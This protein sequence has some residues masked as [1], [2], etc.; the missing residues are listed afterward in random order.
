M[1]GFASNGAW[2]FTAALAALFL[3][4]GLGAA[5]HFVGSG[6]KH[7]GAS[8]HS[9]AVKGLSEREVPASIAVWTVTYSATGNELAEIDGKLTQ[10]TASVSKYLKESGFG[11]TDIAVQP[12]AVVD[13]SLAP[14]GKDDLPPVARFSA[15]QSVLLRTNKVEAVKPAMAGAA[16]LIAAG[17]QLA[18][19]NDPT[20]DFQR[21]NDIKPGM[22]AEATRNAK[23]AAEKFAV[24]SDVKLGKLKR[25]SQGWLKVEDRD[26]ATPEVKIVRVVV[27]VEYEVK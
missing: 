20:F 21:I 24:D 11:D 8:D 5:G 16:K 4:V 1:S 13:L 17:V 15:S 7:R 10:S 6:L 18:A 22:I 9:V 3:A 26:A 12:P 14:R 23:L 27:D 2:P 19:R 25:A